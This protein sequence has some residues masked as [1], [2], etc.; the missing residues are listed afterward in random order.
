MRHCFVALLALTVGRGPAAAAQSPLR[1]FV[2]R[3]GRDTISVEQVQRGPGRVEGELVFRLANQRWHYVLSVGPDER[4]LAM[5]NEF[6]FATDSSSSPARQ[7]AH[8]T[9]TGDSVVVD[10]LAPAAG[11]QRLGSRAGAIPYIN[12]SFGLVE[13]ALRRGSVLGGDTL[14]I[15][16]FA[17][18]GGGTFSGTIHRSGGSDSTAFIVSGVSSRLATGTDGSIRGGGVPSQGLSLEV[19][20]G[21]VMGALVAPK[22]DYTAPADAPYT[23]EA[24]R[25]ST[26]MG[27]T[28]A[29]TLTI[30]KGASGRVPAIVTIT[31]SGLEDRDEAIPPV[32]GYRPFREI[33][34]ALG[35]SGVAVLRMDDRGFG[36]S[37]G[38]P[39]DA[40]TADLAAD[41]RAGLA[42]LRTRPEIDGRRLGLVGHSEGGMIAPLVAVDEPSLQ[43]IVLLAGPA[44]T[45]RRILE[46]QNRYSIDHMPNLSASARDSLMGVARRGID[47]AVAKQAWMRWFIDYDPLVTARKVRTPVLILQGGTDQQ[48]TPE[49]AP[50][51]EAAFRDGGDTDVTARVFPA[52]NH[53]FLADPDGNPADYSR[54]TVVRMRPEVVRS[55]VDWLVKRLF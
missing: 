53:L 20:S 33:A 52:T 6:R 36:E 32:K 29:G 24:V 40:T 45:G 18:A 54:L 19:V 27:H 50:R 41:I 51:L 1:T 7:R 28:L 34:D 43:G 49:Q 22:P 23:A 31:G 26:P 9:F 44:Y 46:F 38:N 42:F 55:L 8:L 10:L 39:T 14:A 25:I 12:P 5:D 48:V 11:Q 4:V 16:L 35:R 30:P 3:A 2:L 15:P 21:A 13:Q 47:S 37:G 17:M